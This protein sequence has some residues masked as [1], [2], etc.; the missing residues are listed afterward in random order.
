[1][2]IEARLPDL[3]RRAHTQVQ[4]AQ[5]YANLLRDP[6]RAGLEQVEDMLRAKPQLV[7]GGAA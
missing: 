3:A 1:M 4:T 5:R 7:Q 2:R 6:L